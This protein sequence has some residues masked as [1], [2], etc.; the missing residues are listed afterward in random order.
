MT[1]SNISRRTLAKGA[2]WTV[3]A[4]AVAAAA[5]SV[6]ASPACDNKALRISKS[7]TTYTITVDKDMDGTASIRI[8]ITCSSSGANCYATLTPNTNLISPRP[9]TGG[10]GTRLFSM[11]PLKAGKYTISATAVGKD[12]TLGTASISCT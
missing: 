5:P 9:S 6:A 3:P 10:S 11:T 12:T 4:V 7:G 8:G 1:D 2:A